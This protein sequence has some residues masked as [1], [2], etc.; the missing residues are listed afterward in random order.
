VLWLPLDEASAK[1]RTGP[2]KEDEEDLGREVW[3]GVLPL[4]LAP[5]DPVADG[6]GRPAPVP[7]HVRGWSRRRR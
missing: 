7:A 1:I 3:A 4:A 5:G 2:P 6:I